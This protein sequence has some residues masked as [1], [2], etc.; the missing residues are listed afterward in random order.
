[1]LTGSPIGGSR[2]R[3]EGSASVV[4]AEFPLESHELEG[5]AY[6]FGKS[7]IEGRSALL[8]VSEVGDKKSLSLHVE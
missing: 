5:T 2:L 1:L 8:V 4:A 6:A 7:T 3:I